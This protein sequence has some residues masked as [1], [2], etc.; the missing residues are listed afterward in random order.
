MVRRI[1]LVNRL[2]LFEKQLI[3][4]SD[5][6][7]YIN[8]NINIYQSP[9][10]KKCYPTIFLLNWIKMQRTNLTWFHETQKLLNSWLVVLLLFRE[11]KIL[12]ITPFVKIILGFFF[13]IQ[14]YWYLAIL[15]INICYP[16][17]Y[18][19]FVF[20]MIFNRRYF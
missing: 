6:F 5:L 3:S 1:V 8:G 18:Y 10:W 19:E 17:R 7:K 11:I 4:T 12:Q 13:Y 2:L 16:I 15:V 20:A 14:G 9:S